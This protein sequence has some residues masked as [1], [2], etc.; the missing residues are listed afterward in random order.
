MT[1][2]SIANRRPGHSPGDGIGPGRTPARPSG[3]ARWLAVFLGLWVGLQPEAAR[4]DLQNASV[5]DIQAA[6]DAGALTSERLVRMYLD[7]IEAYDRKGPTLRA[8]LHLNTNALETARGLDAER[9]AKGARGPLHGVPVIVKDVFDTAD[10]PTSGGFK[11]MADARPTTDAFV[12]ARLRSAGAIILA[13][14]NQ[15]D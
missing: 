5:R 3:I 6:M 2:D 1:I 9:R 14:V 13:K 12:V 4:F 15:S 7:R 8:I 10:M 11:A